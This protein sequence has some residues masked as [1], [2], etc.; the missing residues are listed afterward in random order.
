LNAP[1]RIAFPY[2]R[3]VPVS[4]RRIQCA[5]SSNTASFVQTSNGDYRVRMRAARRAFVPPLAAAEVS[6]VFSTDYDWRDSI[7]SCTLSRRQDALTCR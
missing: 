1:E 4:S 3:C 5:S 2:P 7:A 6:V